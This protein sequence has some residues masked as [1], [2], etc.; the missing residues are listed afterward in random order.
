MPNKAWKAWERRVAHWFGVEREGP[1]GESGLDVVVGGLL[2]VECKQGA[3]ARA[4]LAKLWQEARGKRLEAQLATPL[5]LATSCRLT[6]GWFHYCDEE[7]GHVPWPRLHCVE[8]PTPA[9]L[10]S[11]ERLNRVLEQPLGLCYDIDGETFGC[12]PACQEAADVLVDVA[13]A[14]AEAKGGETSE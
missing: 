10:R 11:L 9:V 12:I 1:V 14:N 6:G 8:V 3:A 5:V 4:P 13:R 7:W 2:C